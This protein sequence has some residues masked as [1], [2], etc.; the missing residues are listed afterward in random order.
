MTTTCT[1]WPTAS[2]QPMIRSL[3]SHALK[4]G[5][6]AP[7]FLL[8]DADGHLHSSEQLCRNEPLVPSFFRGGWCPLCTAEHPFDSQS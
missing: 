4:V 1:W 8:P 2:S 5:D 7:D 6:T 3:A